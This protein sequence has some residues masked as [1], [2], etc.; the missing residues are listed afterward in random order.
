MSHGHLGDV[1]GRQPPLR[2]VT[3]NVL[4]DFGWLSGVFKFTD[5]RLPNAVSVPGHLRWPDWR[6][7]PQLGPSPARRGGLSGPV[8]DA[9]QPAGRRPAPWRAARST[10][11][12]RAP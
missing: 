1:S 9:V 6:V 3:A 8:P 2:R 12:P 4:T 11:S 5:V 10:P 7:A